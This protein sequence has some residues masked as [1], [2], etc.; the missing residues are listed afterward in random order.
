MGFKCANVTPSLHY[1]CVYSFRLRAAL[2]NS[3]LHSRLEG[4]LVAIIFVR[5][6]VVS[7][8]HATG[9]GGSNVFRAQLDVQLAGII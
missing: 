3:I 6:V 8:S 7:T 4:A 2:G 1:S 5:V 9:L